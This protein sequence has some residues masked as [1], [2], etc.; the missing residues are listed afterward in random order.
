MG[1]SEKTLERA[2]LEAITSFYAQA[3]RL[4]FYHSE[5]FMAPLVAELPGYRPLSLRA[6]AGQ[7]LARPPWV[8]QRGR[9]TGDAS[10]HISHPVLGC[11]QAL[12]LSSSRCGPCSVQLGKSFRWEKKRPPG[13]G[14][15]SQ[16]KGLCRKGTWCCEPS[17]TPLGTGENPDS[18]SGAFICGCQI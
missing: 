6:E 16:K 18:L 15:G 2:H 12:S 13:Q 10:F 3:L 1:A 5:T 7:P 4:A 8:V 9:G 14:T 11:G 17:T